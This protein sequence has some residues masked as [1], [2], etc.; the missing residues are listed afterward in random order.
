[1]KKQKTEAEIDADDQKPCWVK[2]KKATVIPRKR[3]L[4]K[5]MILESFAILCCG[6]DSGD[7]KKHEK[8]NVG[9]STTSN[10]KK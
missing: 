10:A 4:V 8:V 9:F 3:R 1:M 6:S 2:P 7:S 5:T